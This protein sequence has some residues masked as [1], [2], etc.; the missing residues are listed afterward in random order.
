MAGALRHEILSGAGTRPLPAPGGRD[1]EVLGTKTAPLP[2][3]H[4][5]AQKVG[6]VVVGV[7]IVLLLLA[8]GGSLA[9]FL[10]RNPAPAPIANQTSTSEVAAASSPVPS[11]LVGQSYDAA[12]TILTG[13]GF[14]PVKQVVAGS[15]AAKDEVLSVRPT[16][17]S[18]VSPGATITLFVGAGLPVPPPVKPGHDHGHGKDKGHEKGK[19]KKH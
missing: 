12:A 19:G 2:I 10:G 6:R 9:R 14:K 3:D 8:V 13:Q 7:A 16:E 1:T 17:G 18:A 15:T 11:G 4:W 5:N